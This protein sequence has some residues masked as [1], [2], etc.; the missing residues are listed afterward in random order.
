MEPPRSNSTPESDE[1]LLQELIREAE[2]ALDFQ[3]R[4][5]ERADGRA[6]QMI[7]LATGALVAGW[8]VGSA[9]MGGRGGSPPALYLALRAAGS[10]PTL[11]SI[12]RFVGAYLGVREHSAIRIGPTPE[13]LFAEA[14]RSATGLED[15]QR[16]ALQIHADNFVENLQGLS[17]AVRERDRGV[18]WLLAGALLF[19]SAFLYIGGG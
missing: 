6:E 8:G 19:G 9:L 3:V 11:I 16:R 12:G 14:G 1:A 17:A 15:H 10:L 7:G 18:R 5:F 4:A 13:W 2:R